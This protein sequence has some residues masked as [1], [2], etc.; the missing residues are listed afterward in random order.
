MQVVCNGAVSFYLMLED[1]RASDTL[2]PGCKVCL[3]V[4]VIDYLVRYLQIPI[5]PNLL[6]EASDDSF[7]PLGHTQPP[8]L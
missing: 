3:A 2:V 4:S 8:F 6:K 7:V 5:V 1:R